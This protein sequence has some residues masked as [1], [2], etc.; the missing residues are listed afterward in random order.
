MV[1]KFWPV[2][3]PKA[4]SV[5]ASLRNWRSLRLRADFLKLQKN[6]QKWITPSFVIQ[7]S[8][9]SDS[10]SFPSTPPEI[11]FTATKKLGGAVIR[12]R[13]RR[14]LRAM[15]D[16]VTGDFALNGVQCAIIARSDAETREF[17]QMVRDLRWAFRRLNIAEHKKEKDA[18][19]A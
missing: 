8:D 5:C 13:C 14:R 9:R 16:E 11:G 6:G 10:D 19:R 7:I 18:A 12:N 15:C 4:A 2:V 17:D 3:V 1:K